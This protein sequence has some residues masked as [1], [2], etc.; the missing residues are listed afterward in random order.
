MNVSVLDN[1]N[2][3]TGCG[4]CYSIC[5][6]KCISMKEDNEGFLYPVCNPNK[7]TNCNLCRK[8]CPAINSHKEKLSEL[9]EA[10]VGW[11]NDEFLREQATSGGVFSAIAK[12]FLNS[13]GIVYG[14]AYDEQNMVHHIRIESEDQ[15][16]LI[17]RSKYV[18]S[19]T[20]QTFVSVLEE[21]K[22]NK[23]VLYSGTTCQIYG[24][25]S[26][27]KTKKI[28]TN[29][30]YTIDLVC[31]GVPSPKLLR[32]YLKF[33]KE[34]RDSDVISISMREKSTLPPFFQR[35]SLWLII[36]IKKDI[37]MLQILIIME[38]FFLVKYLK[39]L[40]VISVNINLSDA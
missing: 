6:Q 14:A 8:V 20:E 37:K 18:Q 25:L 15:L 21:L 11:A 19:N 34:T 24:L 23:A 38:E 4:A 13:G 35:L 26:F 30:L 36:Q 31:H 33:H 7:C 17:N 27:L 2:L 32:E 5:P 16:C 39:D 22:N 12:D 29:N 9:P 28:K 40:Y 10:Y 3:C 1:T